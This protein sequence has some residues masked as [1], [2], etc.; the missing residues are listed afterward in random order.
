MAAFL[1]AIAV[2]VMLTALGLIA[3]SARR[4][5]Q[6][7]D[8]VPRQQQPVTTITIRPERRQIEAPR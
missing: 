2:V 5:H 1:A 7:P 3:W 4:V 8:Y 6:A